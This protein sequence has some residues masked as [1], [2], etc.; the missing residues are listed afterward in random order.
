MYEMNACMI[1]WEHGSMNMWFKKKFNVCTAFPGIGIQDCWD[2]HGDKQYEQFYGAC[3]KR[4][5]IQIQV[6]FY[7]SIDYEYIYVR[8]SLW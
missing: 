5:T 7:F 8:V 3:N 2:K 4:V 1:I 6:R